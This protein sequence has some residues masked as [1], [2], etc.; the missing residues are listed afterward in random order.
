[1]GTMPEALCGVHKAHLAV[2]SSE[3]LEGLLVVMAIIQTYV[4]YDLV[5]K[6]LVR[7]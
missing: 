7:M 5:P 3:G 4:V 1:M 6:I 2:I